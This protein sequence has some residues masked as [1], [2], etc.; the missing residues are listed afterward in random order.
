MEPPQ[1]PGCD[2]SPCLEAV[3]PL[4]VTEPKEP[5]GQEAQALGYDNI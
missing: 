5:L 2:G 4:E 3:E 1:A